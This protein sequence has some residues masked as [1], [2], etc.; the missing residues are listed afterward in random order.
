[1]VIIKMAFVSYSF[2]GFKKEIQKLLR[3]RISLKGRI[4]YHISKIERLKTE[5]VE[6]EKELDKFL[7]LAGN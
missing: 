1:M 7:K 3:A 6:K 4:R 2:G 5:L